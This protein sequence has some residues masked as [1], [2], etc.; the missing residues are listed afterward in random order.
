MEVGREEERERE[1]E[2]RET[3][4]R[5]RDLEKVGRSVFV[6]TTWFEER[7]ER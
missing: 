5:K 3:L 6:Q 1:E 4:V 2:E 7:E